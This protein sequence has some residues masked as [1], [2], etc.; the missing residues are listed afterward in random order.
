M[1][2]YARLQLGQLDEDEA[3]AREEIEP[4]F[5]RGGVPAMYGRWSLRGRV[6]LTQAREV[7]A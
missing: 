4:P 5:E 2:W 1:L 7:L 3:F 6:V